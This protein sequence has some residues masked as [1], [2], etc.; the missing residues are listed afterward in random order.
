MAKVYPQTPTFASSLTSKRETFTIWMKSLM[1]QG[2]GCTVFDS[3]G[4]IVYRIDNY[5]E[6]CCDEVH[7]MNLRGKVLFSIR[8]KKLQV[9]GRWEGYKWGDSRMKKERPLFQVRKYCRLLSK[10]IICR[11]ILGRDKAKARCY[12]IVGLAGKSAFKIIDDDGALAA[13]VKS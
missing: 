10:E 6:K 2:N 1:F 11:V 8:Q 4:E 3:N 9:F 13:E 7:L 12:R 5:N